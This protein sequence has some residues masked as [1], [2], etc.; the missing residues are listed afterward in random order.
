MGTIIQIGKAIA[1]ILREDSAV[2]AAVGTNVFPLIADEKT[3]FPF[4]IYRRVSGSD[5]TTKDSRYSESCTVEI[6]VIA[7]D[8]LASV[9]IATA[10]KNAMENFRSNYKGDFK[11]Q[12]INFMGSGEQYYSNAYTQTL[13]FEITINL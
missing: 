2:K 8:Y 7:D 11:I 10:V 3:P 13:Q 9:N 6:A 5:A 1:E 4:I 12:K